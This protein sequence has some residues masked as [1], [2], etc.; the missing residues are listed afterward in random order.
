MKETRRTDTSSLMNRPR[1]F[2]KTHC[3]AFASGSACK[4]PRLSVTR[5]EVVVV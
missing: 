4:E 2:F 1:S 3:K 5:R